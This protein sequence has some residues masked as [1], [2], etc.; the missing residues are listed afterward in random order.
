MGQRIYFGLS[1]DEGAQPQPEL[2]IVG[3]SYVGPR[4]FVQ[5]LES[6]GDRKSVV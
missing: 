3:T 6:H 5:L 1:F 4:Q 2:P